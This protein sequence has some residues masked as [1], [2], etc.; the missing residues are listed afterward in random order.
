M[1]IVGIFLELLGKVQHFIT[2]QVT[3]LSKPKSAKEELAVTLHYLTTDETVENLM[4]QKLIWFNLQRDETGNGLSNF[5]G[6]FAE[7]F[8]LQISVLH[9]CMCIL[10][11][12]PWL[13]W[14]I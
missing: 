3:H 11:A 13:P 10:E 7:C 1:S 14:L 8:L 5:K 12:D 6:T 9:Q 4:E 2:T